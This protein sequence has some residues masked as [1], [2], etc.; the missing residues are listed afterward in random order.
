MKNSNKKEIEVLEKLYMTWSTEDL[1]KAATVHKNDYKPDSIGLILKEIKRRNLSVEDFSEIRS[2]D[3][4]KIQAEVKFFSGV[5]GFLLLFVVILIVTVFLCVIVIGELSIVTSEPN[6]ISF[7]LSIPPYIVG[8]Y[9]VFTFFALALRN[10]SASRHAKRWFIITFVVNIMYVVIALG[11]FLVLNIQRKSAIKSIQLML[12]QYMS[13]QNVQQQS[14]LK[15]KHSGGV[16]I[17]DVDSQSLHNLYKKRIS[18]I[19]SRHPMY[20]QHSSDVR[21]IV[22][23]SHLTEPVAKYSGGI[24]IS[25]ADSNDPLF[26]LY[27]GGGDTIEVLKEN[28]ELRIVDIETKSVIANTLLQGSRPNPK[29]LPTKIGMLMK[30]GNDT[31]F[32][33]GTEGE[34]SDPDCWNFFYWRVIF[35]RNQPVGIAL[36]PHLDFDDRLESWV[37]SYYSK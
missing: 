24:W 34:I 15:K 22:F 7:V 3:K 23:L 2:A 5:R 35:K 8:L 13:L 27:H 18:S 29:C 31:Y 36:G 11:C 25:G 30:Q 21:T 10:K 1:I 17:V 26:K 9:G 19:F 6:I 14:S 4:R 28:I 33:Q 16:I 32:L 20:A 12:N 37:A